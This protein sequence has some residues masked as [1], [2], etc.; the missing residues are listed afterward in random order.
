MVFLYIC[1]ALCINTSIFTRENL[2]HIW[3]HTTK[4]TSETESLPLA[5]VFDTTTACDSQPSPSCRVPYFA[6][7]S[8]RAKLPE[9]QWR[10]N[11]PEQCHHV[12][13][14]DP[15]PKEESILRVTSLPRMIR[16]TPCRC[17]QKYHQDLSRPATP[18]NLDTAEGVIS[19]LLYSV[20]SSGFAQYSQNSHQYR[21]HR[22]QWYVSQY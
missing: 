7:H 9:A 3:S 22:C 21:A 8:V 20:H 15:S 16:W 6:S 5:S 13:V 2:F 12:Q 18:S 19:G 14:L 11:P 17:C 1:L 4:G 10:L